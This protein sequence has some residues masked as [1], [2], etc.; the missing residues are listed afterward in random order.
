[1]VRYGVR[2]QYH[3]ETRE[4]TLEDG[5][6]LSESRIC[7]AWSDR[8]NRDRRLCLTSVGITV[9]INKNV[10]FRTRQPIYY[11]KK[12]FEFPYMLCH[13]RSV[14][15]LRPRP[16][17]Q[18]LPVKAAVQIAIVWTTISHAYTLLYIA[19]TKDRQLNTAA[20]AQTNSI[21]L[22]TYCIDIKA[23]CIDK[24]SHPKCLFST[25]IGSP[26]YSSKAYDLP[27]C[28]GQCDILILVKLF[29]A[30]EPR[31]TKARILRAV[32]PTT[33]TWKSI[34]SRSESE[35]WRNFLKNKKDLI[36]NKLPH[37]HTLQRR[38]HHHHQRALRQ[39]V[40]PLRKRAQ[41]LW[42]Y[43]MR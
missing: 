17:S 18:S 30:R 14:S 43:W 16:L 24:A 22:K 2:K 27:L 1:M 11:N 25:F 32:F 9:T 35:S 37:I 3:L 20:V 23:Y 40:L 13:P 8:S 33:Q 26:A 28:V 15:H 19:Y 39:N 4:K 31:A 5:V 41:A 34:T 36:L 42:R 21:N 29:W 10:N 38:Q 12:S 6:W 7:Q